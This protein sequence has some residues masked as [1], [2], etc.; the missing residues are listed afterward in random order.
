MAAPDGDAAACLIAFAGGLRSGMHPSIWV[1]MIVRPFM[2]PG[3]HLYG[4]GVPVPARLLRNGAYL[5]VTDPGRPGRG[6]KPRER[7]QC[8]NKQYK[9]FSRHGKMISYV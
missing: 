6:L 1:F 9:N 8:Y 2:R 3:L 7:Q 5:L 4:A